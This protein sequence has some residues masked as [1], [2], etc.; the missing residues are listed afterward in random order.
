MS[1]PSRFNWRRWTV[2]VV[3]WDSDTPQS[4]YGRLLAR[5]TERPKL[6]ELGEIIASA[7]VADRE[8]A[9]AAA[10][11]FIDKFAH[12]ASGT[13]SVEVHISGPEKAIEEEWESRLRADQRRPP[14]PAPA[15]SDAS[16]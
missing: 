4:R 2:D 14:R 11:D 12:A 15:S 3:R 1:K 6:T 10:H 7:Q 9:V 5:K 8:A 13:V 16:S